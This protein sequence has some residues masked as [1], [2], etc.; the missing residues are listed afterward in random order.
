MG[1]FAVGGI[2]LVTVACIVRRMII[3][4]KNGKSLHCGCCDKDCGCHCAK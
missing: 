1:T 2:L 4:K 3:N